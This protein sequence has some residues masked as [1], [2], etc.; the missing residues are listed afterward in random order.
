MHPVQDAFIFE[1]TFPGDRILENGK[2]GLSPLKAVEI[3]L[4]IPAGFI[5]AASQHGMERQGP[6]KKES[7]V[8]VFVPF[9]NL[10]F[11]GFQDR[12]VPV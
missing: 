8:P 1:G 2:F 9:E 3:I 4:F 12:S 11:N 5:T 6:G 7:A 10:C